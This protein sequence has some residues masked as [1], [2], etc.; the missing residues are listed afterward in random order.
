M[1]DITQFTLLVM[2]FFPLRN[3]NI[4]DTKISDPN[5]KK[6]R[7]VRKVVRDRSTIIHGILLLIVVGVFIWSVIKPFRYVNWALEVLPAI[8]LLVIVIITYNKFRL[9]TLSYFII[10]I[11]TILMFIGGH[12]TYSRVP[13][14]DWIKDYFDLQRNNYDRFGHFLKGLITIVIR[15]VLIRKS[16]LTEGKWLYTVTLSIALSIGTLYEIIEWLGTKIIKGGKV[17]KDFLGTQGD[18]WDTQWDL[19]LLL[20]GAILALL[21][22]SSLHNKQLRNKIEN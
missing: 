17:S 18:I 15:E 7:E 4:T 5:I 21:F 3:N 19:F 10:A 13:L 12:Y 8:V 2:I 9:T 14:F 16:P 6:M 1:Q 20:I 22:F 11:L